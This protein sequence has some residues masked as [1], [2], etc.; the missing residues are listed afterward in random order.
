MSTY[1]VDASVAAKWFIE[2]E[3]TAAARSVVDQRNDLHVP[4]MFLVETDSIVCKWVRRGI[5]T[6]AD[7]GGIRASIRGPDLEFHPFGPLL[8]SAYAIAAETG[9]GIYDCLYVALAALVGGP[10]VTADRRLYDGLAGGGYARHVLWIE[11]VP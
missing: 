8:D 11:D 2:E 1:V 10:M 3:H 4:D 6:A 9:Q 7:G 5:I